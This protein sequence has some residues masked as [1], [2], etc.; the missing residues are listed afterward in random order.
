MVQ[1]H[2]KVLEFERVQSL[3]I[4]LVKEFVLFVIL[5]AMT[6]SSLPGVYWPDFVA[7]YCRAFFFVDRQ[8]DPLK[9]GRVNA[10]NGGSRSMVAGRRAFIMRAL[11]R[12]RS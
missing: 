4:R 1:S 7:S 10:S 8:R 3:D 11:S 9:H 12:Q 6:L 2:E 5:K